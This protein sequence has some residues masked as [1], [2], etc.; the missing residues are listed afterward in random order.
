[1]R[2]IMALRGQ[3]NK[4]HEIG[5]VDVEATSVKRGALAGINLKTH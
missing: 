5:Q 4:G 2:R 1:M 3:D